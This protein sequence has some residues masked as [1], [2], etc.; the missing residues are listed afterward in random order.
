M[1]RSSGRLVC[2]FRPRGVLQIRQMSTQP[3]TIHITT[4]A[5]FA[6]APPLASA[7]TLLGVLAALAYFFCR[8]GPTLAR[9]AGWCSWWVAWA[10]GS[11]GG[12]AYGIAFAIFGTLAWGGGTVWYVRRRGRWPSALSAR[13]LTRLLGRRTPLTRT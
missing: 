4:A 1:L 11:Q 13:L 12:Y 7:I 10:C 2:P 5:H 6:T 3:A 9:V 8:F